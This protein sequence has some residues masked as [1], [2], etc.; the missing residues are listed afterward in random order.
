MEIKSLSKLFLNELESI[1]LCNTLNVLE[2]T[3]GVGVYNPTIT[4][5]RLVKTMSYEC[6]HWDCFI[7]SY[8][9]TCEGNCDG[10]SGARN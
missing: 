4:E 1:K 3:N 9:C 6:D 10:C 7:S 5:K 8:S 2:A